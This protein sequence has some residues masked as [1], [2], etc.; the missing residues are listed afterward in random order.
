MKR[1]V[2]VVLISILCSLIYATGISG[3]YFGTINPIVTNENKYVSSMSEYQFEGNR[4]YM[5]MDVPKGSKAEKEIPSEFLVAYG[6]SYNEEG[7]FSITSTTNGIQSISFCSDS[8]FT[9]KSELGLLYNNRRLFLFEDDV[10]FFEPSEGYQWDGIMPYV[11]AVTTSSKLKEKERI[12]SGESFMRRL[13]SL[14]PWVEAV[15]DQGIGEWID[16]SIKV[17]GQPLTSVL[18]SNGYVS[19][20]KPNLYLNN[21]RIKDLRITCKDINLDMSVTLQD[22]PDLQEIVLPSPIQDTEISIRFII[23]STYSGNK[24]SDTCVSLIYPLGENP[25]SEDNLQ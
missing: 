22:I 15:P 24:W 2:I 18:I 8:K 11:T 14:L 9:Y 6:T 10:I 3:Q 5:T 13:P 7:T 1:A 16:L 4:Y 21:S 20:T 12:Y 25:Y 23:E 17:S 19:F